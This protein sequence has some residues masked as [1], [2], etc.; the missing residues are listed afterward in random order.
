MRRA[1]ADSEAVTYHY[2]ERMGFG[3][4]MAKTIRAYRNARIALKAGKA[5]E[6][7]RKVI[8]S[9]EEPIRSGPEPVMDIPLAARAGFLF[10]EGNE[11]FTWTFVS[12]PA[13][14]RPGPRTGK[15]DVH[16]DLVPLAPESRRTE[17]SE[18]P[19]DG[20]MLGINVPDLAVA[21]VDEME[22]RE[23]IGK[24]W[25]ATADL[26]DDEPRSSYAKLS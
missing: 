15:Y 16:I 24:H 25:S 13:I 11:T 17:G 21:I 5:T 18:N 7:D 4:P 6:D 19:Y 22:K 14:Y 23:K 20:R 10:F 8:E 26:V 9:I 3:S 2:E 12:P 1:N